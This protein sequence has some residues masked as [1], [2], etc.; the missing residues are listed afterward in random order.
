M[1]VIGSALSHSSGSGWILGTAAPTGSGAGGTCPHSLL[2]GSIPSKESADS[3]SPAL[4]SKGIG[5]GA[6]SGRCGKLS[7]GSLKF[8]G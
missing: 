3:P 7:N 5:L 4:K 1:P 8:V 6:C 2:G